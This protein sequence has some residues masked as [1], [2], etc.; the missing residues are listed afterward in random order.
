M[1]GRLEAAFPGLTNPGDWR[2]RDILKCLGGALALAGLD[3]CE[4]MPDEEALPFV[5]QPEGEEPGIAR[6]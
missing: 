5:V 2:R 1:R 6:Y 3:G 4:R